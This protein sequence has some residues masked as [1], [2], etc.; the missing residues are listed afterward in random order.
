[1][2]TL[3]NTSI[4]YLVPLILMFVAC[5]PAQP[6]DLTGKWLTADNTW[7]LAFEGSQVSEWEGEE[8]QASGS[9]TLL[10]QDNGLVLT[11]NMESGGVLSFTTEL[12]DRDILYLTPMGQSSQIVLKRQ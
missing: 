8:K 6:P 12:S 11:V 2:T 5:T 10:Q 1:M 7:G 4:L 9:F 3:K